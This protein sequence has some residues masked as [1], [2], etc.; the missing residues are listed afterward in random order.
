[1]FSRGPGYLSAAVLYENLVVESALDPRYASKP[2]PVVAVYPREGTF[3]SDHPYAILNLPSVTPEIREAAEAFK[4]YLLSP[5]RQRTAMTRFGFRPTDPSIALG[6]P[7]DAAHG[8]DP[9]Q[10]QNVLPNPTVSVTRRIIDG[11]EDVKRPVALTFVLDTSGSM[12]GA[13]LQ[14]AKVGA[15]T[16]L[17]GLPAADQVRLLFFANSPRWQSTTAE[18]VGTARGRLVAA[19]DGSFADGG[20]ALYDA[21]LAA[22]TPAPGAIR[23]ASRAVIVLTDGQD[24]D[25]Q[26]KIDALLAELQRRGP[27]G[28]GAMGED[29]PRVFTIAYGEKADAQVL[30]RIAEAG[31]GAFFKGTPR[32]I[33]AV[34]AE[35]ATF[36]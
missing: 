7:L 36:F 30:Q 20:T 14:Q 34:Y 6:P 5:E 22:L 27:A 35:L 13:P 28:E 19:V 2:F 18:P 3:W 8:L 25:S 12:N 4:A 17:E 29:P 32:D 11:F 24:T 21:I 23:G 1:M 9:Q 10:P 33:Q 26:N 15:R 31:G 16:F